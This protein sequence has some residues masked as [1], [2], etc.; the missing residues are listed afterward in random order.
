MSVYR[1]IY[2][3]DFMEVDIKVCSLWTLIH[4]GALLEILLNTGLPLHNVAYTICD[5]AVFKQ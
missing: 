1:Y 5:S 4:K 3:I 2:F